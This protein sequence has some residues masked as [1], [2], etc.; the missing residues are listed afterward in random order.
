MKKIA[1]V[2]TFAVLALILPHHTEAQITWLPIADMTKEER[3]F[4]QNAIESAT[5]KPAKYLLARAMG[6]RIRSDTVFILEKSNGGDTITILV[7]GAK[8]GRSE[9]N[10]NKSVEKR[11]ANEQNADNASAE[12]QQQDTQSRFEKDSASCAKASQPS[13]EGGIRSCIIF[14]WPDENDDEVPTRIAIVNGYVEEYFGLLI[15][16]KEIDLGMIADKGNRYLRETLAIFPHLTKEQ[17]VNFLELYLFSF[18]ARP[19]DAPSQSEKQ[20][21]IHQLIKLFQDGAVARLW[22]TTG[23][24][25]KDIDPE[26]YEVLRKIRAFPY[27]GSGI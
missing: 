21:A 26:S 12:P 25:I 10:Q 16:K 24:Y 5:K 7:S 9:Q 13:R 14:L 11:G 8:Q 2:V 3:V 1:V 18:K 19:E 23:Y 20:T 6:F 17:Q 15:S 4:V 22:I 27:D